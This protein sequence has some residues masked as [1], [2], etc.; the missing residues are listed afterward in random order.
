MI[1][2]DTILYS[3][4]FERYWCILSKNRS[5]SQSVCCSKWSDRYCELFFYHCV[6]TMYVIHIWIFVSERNMNQNQTF[7]KVFSQDS[8]ILNI[9]HYGGHLEFQSPSKTERVL[10]LWCLIPLNNIS[11]ISWRSVLMVENTGAPG[12]NYWSAT[13]IIGHNWE[14][15]EFIFDFSVFKSSK[16]YRGL[17]IAGYTRENKW[18]EFHGKRSLIEI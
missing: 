5:K 6:Y 10:G 8:S 4:F 9:V 13:S 12:E 17:I 11:V 7:T 3:Y 14:T 15:W 1:K 18:R 2:N 16:C